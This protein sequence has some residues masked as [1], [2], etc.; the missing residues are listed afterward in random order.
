MADSVDKRREVEVVESLEG[1]LA[2]LFLSR[3]KSDDVPSDIGRA[4]RV[5]DS[6]RETLPKSRVL[7]TIF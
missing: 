2:L 1:Q 7:R 6:R 4:G 3:V 5:W